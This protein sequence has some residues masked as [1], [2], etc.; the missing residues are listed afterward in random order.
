MATETYTN[1]KAV[2][3]DS[4][5]SHTAS[6]MQ[7]WIDDGRPDGRIDNLVKSLVLNAYTSGAEEVTRL[8]RDLGFVHGDLRRVYALLR[9]HGINALAEP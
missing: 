6:L 2:V 7:E 9:E 8:R 3:S 4:V 5:R 1:Y